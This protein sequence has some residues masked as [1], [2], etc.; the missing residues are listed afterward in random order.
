MNLLNQENAAAT[1]RF[2]YE[3]ESGVTDFEGKASGITE[4]YE[5]DK[6]VVY[7]GLGKNKEDLFVFAD[8]A[9]EAVRRVKRLKKMSVEIC[10]PQSV[11]RYAEIAVEAAV[12]ADYAFDGYLSEK[13]VR[14]EDLYLRDRENMFDW[15]KLREAKIVAEAVNYARNLSNENAAVVTPEYLA[16]EARNIAATCENMSL[17]ILDDGEI[18]EKNLN[19]LWAVGKGSATP[20]R[21]AIVSYR[22]DEESGGTCAL[23]GKGLT[24]DSGGLNLKPAGSIETMKHDMSGAASVLGVLRAAAVL[25]PKVNFIVA[26]PAA[27]SAIGKDAFIVGAVYRSY[28]GKTVEVL[29]TD[30][31]GRLILADAFEY[32]I[33]NYKPTEI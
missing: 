2:V 10:L 30:A 16:R 25:K 8:A 12:M 33:A 18:R 21:L 26:I 20:P 29:N 27:Q 24:F 9:T 17:E 15:D 1:I 28:S 32:L 4:R 5:D 6:P 23:V 13:P 11:Q 22:G 3:N 31:E 19:L 14:I 7:A